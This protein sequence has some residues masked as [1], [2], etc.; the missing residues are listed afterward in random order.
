MSY[1]QYVLLRAKEKYL[2]YRRVQ[3][4][5]FALFLVSVLVLAIVIGWGYKEGAFNENTK[6][7][8]EELPSFC[9][10]PGETH[11]QSALAQCSGEKGPR[12]IRQRDR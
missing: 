1:H 4:E 3:A 2:D 8:N 12:E 5:E 6:D 10:G 7:T 9:A 11:D